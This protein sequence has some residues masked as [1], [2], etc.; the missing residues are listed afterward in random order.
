V[1]G[2]PGSLEVWWCGWDED[3]LVETEKEKCWREGYK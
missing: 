1:T 3:I 2:G